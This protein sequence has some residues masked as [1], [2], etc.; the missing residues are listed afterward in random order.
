MVGHLF[1]NTNCFVTVCLFLEVQPVKE[2]PT[3]TERDI[4]KYQENLKR[5]QREDPN[6]DIS[7]YEDWD[8]E[9]M[10]FPR[11]GYDPMATIIR[12]NRSG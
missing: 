3:M 5:M 8:I 2:T 4:Y 12:Y 1:I 7:T 9:S 10:M 11:P 6:F